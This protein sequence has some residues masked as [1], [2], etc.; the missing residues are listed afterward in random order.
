M[1]LYSKS[2]QQFLLDA[3]NAITPGAISPADMENT[4][5][6]LPKAIAAALPDSPNTEITLRGRQ[7]R[8]YTGTQ[9]FRYRRLSLNDL[10][11]NFV[12]Q[13]TAPTAY[14]WLT[15][16]AKKKAFAQNL[17][18]R[19]GL[20]LVAADIPDQF[21][22]L[23]VENTL[24][25]LSSCLQYTGS[26][27]FMSIRGKNDLEELVLNDVLDTLNH[28]VAVEDKLCLPLLSYGWD[29][30]DEQQLMSGFVN[31]SLSVGANATSGRTDQLMALLVE[32]GIPSFD[33]TGA[34]ITRYLT[35]AETR[36]NTRYD[37]VLV[38]T[39]IRDVNVAGDCL[40]HYNN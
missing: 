2:Q 5:F 7:G 37:N 22:Q 21:V 25:V 38:I 10:F 33:P 34:R 8:G 35:T 16:E 17:N 3:I 30:T 9:T 6:G 12:P 27:T 15:T 19:Y 31:G 39:G 40:L 24:G 1:P 4:T 36:A 23:N 18:G 11:K 20:N 28:P 26:I 29:F 14:G 32:R 13:V